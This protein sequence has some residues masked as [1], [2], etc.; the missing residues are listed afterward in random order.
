MRSLLPLASRIFL[1]AIG[2]RLL[3]AFIG[4]LANVTL[5][6]FQD[7]GFTVFAG[8]HP[9]W[10]AFARYDA[11]W[12][13]NIASSGYT[14]G[15]GVPDKLAFFPLYP[16]LMRGL[17]TLFG[18]RREDFYFAGIVISWL[19]FA[20]AMVML[21]KLARLD[22]DERGARRA[23][24]YAAVFPF[25]YFFGVVYSESLF[26]LALVTA[27]YA[28]RTR[29][30]ALAAVAGAAMTATRVTGVMALPGLAWLAWQ[31]A[32][33]E[34]RRGA[35]GRGDT[36]KA[37]AAVAASIAGIGLYSAYNYSVSGDPFAWYDAITRWNYHPGQNPVAMPIAA[38]WALISRPLQY[39]SERM[40]PYDVLNTLAAVTALALVPIIW[41]RFG[42]GYALV[43]LGGMLLPL[44]SG[45]LEGLGRYAS[46]QF[47]IALALASG[48]S[49]T[50]HAITLAAFAILYVI[51]FAL[52]A[53]VHPLF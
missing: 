26:F 27:A 3:S 17:G 23:T 5:P 46:V 52:F 1:A 25:A 38:I 48:G 44:S 37:A 16:A 8:P 29:Q 12:Y 50:R 40:A 4:Y 51:C 22:L 7:Q 47:P 11:G 10:D 9:F 18:S 49:R 15:L 14:R 2:F 33:V 34:S 20:A 13:Y 31:A 35:T 32:R 53:T 19:A 42:A 21:Y 45:Q 28:L 6:Q 30:W 41:R 43:V 24:L 36:V 39:L